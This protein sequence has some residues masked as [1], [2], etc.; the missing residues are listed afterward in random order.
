MNSIWSFASK[1]KNRQI[2]SW[3]G[4]G[5]VV[6]AGGIWAVITFL[7]T[8]DHSGGRPPSTV[9]QTTSGPESPAIANVRGNVTVNSGREKT[10]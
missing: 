6:V 1:P 5:I 7:W 9:T 10:P 8:P 2:I 3:I 4:S